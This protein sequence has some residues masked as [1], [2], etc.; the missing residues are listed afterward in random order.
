M[1]LS[2]FPVLANIYMEW[3][4]NK[5]PNKLN[6]SI[7]LSYGWAMLMIFLLFG[8]MVRNFWIVFEPAKY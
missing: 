3:F 5:I 8:H 2:L 4:G 6:T 1:G 7:N